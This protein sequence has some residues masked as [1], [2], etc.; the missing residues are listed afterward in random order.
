VLGFGG[1]PFAKDQLTGNVP[2]EEMVDWFNGQID[3]GIDVARLKESV[4]IAGRIFN[5]VI[6]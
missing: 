6:G 3:T 1:C 5:P 2:M 4:S